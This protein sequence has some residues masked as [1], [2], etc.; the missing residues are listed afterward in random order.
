MKLI[1]G[2]IQELSNACGRL[3][4]EMAEIDKDLSV[5]RVDEPG[6]IA[7]FLDTVFVRGCMLISVHRLDD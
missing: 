4:H 6:R 2:L 3:Q 5:L 1:V 7:K